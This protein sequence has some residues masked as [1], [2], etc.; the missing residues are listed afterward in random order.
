MSEGERRETMRCLLVGL[1]GMGQGL[2]R[3]LEQKPWFEPAGVVDVRPEAIDAG[4]A[5]LHLPPEARFIDLDSALER[6]A[7]DAAI[8]NTP[9]GL[10]YEQSRAALEAGAHVLVAKPVTRSF[11][12]AAD[13]VRLAEQEGRTLG[14]GQQIRYNRHYTA[15][16]RFVRSGALGRPGAAWLMNSKP[17]P[18]VRNLG[19]ETQPALLETAIHHLDSLLAV[20]SGHAPG[21]VMCDGFRPDW[22]PYDGP[23][24]VNLLLRL[25][26]GLHIFLHSGFSARAPMYEFRIEGTEGALRCRGLHMSNDLMRYEFANALGPFEDAP[27]DKDVPLVNP[28]VRF[29]D[30]WHDYVRGGEEPPFSGRNNL[31]VMATVC[32]AIESLETGRPVDIAGSPRYAAAFGNGDET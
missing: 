22:S 28:W 14:V 20:F 8:I 7:A 21:W 13:L 9:S 24:M 26:G 17:R 23:C 18:D 27:I 31:P 4:Q 3:F 32:A 15:V 29:L 11:A 12:E 10:H 16:A 6:T 2:I 5:A 19:G 1:G 25:R 30:A